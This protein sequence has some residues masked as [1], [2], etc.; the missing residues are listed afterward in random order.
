MSRSF[1]LV[2][3]RRT[4]V[5]HTHQHQRV[6]RAKP[7]G[8]CL[9]ARCEG[10]V[11]QAF[12]GREEPCG[13]EPPSSQPWPYRSVR[14]TDSETKRGGPLAKFLGAPPVGWHVMIATA[15]DATAVR[16]QPLH[17]LATAHRSRRPRFA[18]RRGL[19]ICLSCRQPLPSQ[20]RGKCGHE[21]LARD[22]EGR[23][24]KCRARVGVEVGI[25]ASEAWSVFPSG[26]GASDRVAHTHHHQRVGRIKPCGA[27][28]GKRRCGLR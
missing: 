28:L 22:N 9:G 21:R 26:A 6:G 8:V 10:G 5:A 17:A 2:L 27:G 1:P 20:V 3:V 23:R 24:C 25:V 15:A 13:A 7:C 19:C 16:V 18:M 12:P 14:E 4:G 11:G